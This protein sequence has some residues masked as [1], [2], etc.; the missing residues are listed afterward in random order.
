MRTIN[1]KASQ[2]FERLINLNLDKIDNTKGTFMPLYFE[3]E[4]ELETAD[5]YSLAHY[6][7]QNGDMMA[8]P[9]MKF[10]RLRKTGQIF[11]FYY[12]LDSLGIYQTS[13]FFE[14]GKAT[15]FNPKMQKDHA[16]FANMWLRNIESQQGI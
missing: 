16:F 14:D 13:I 6:F 8:D 2:I 12:G 7:K 10:Y 3:K 5:V 4:E 15:K 11:P 9:I 1:I